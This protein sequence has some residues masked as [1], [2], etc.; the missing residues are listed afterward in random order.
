MKGGDAV[1]PKRSCAAL[2]N[3]RG[4]VSPEEG[5]SHLGSWAAAARR[6]PTGAAPRRSLMRRSASSQ[7]A[8]LR[9]AWRGMG[10]R[11][12][13]EL[14]SPSRARRWTSHAGARARISHIDEVGALPEGCRR[15]S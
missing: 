11:S 9:D 7:S 3:Q 10:T 13:G 14:E 2:I 5:P 8:A 1:A 6:D 15:G 12:L 4:K